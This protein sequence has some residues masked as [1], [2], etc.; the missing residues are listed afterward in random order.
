VLERQAHLVGQVHRPFPVA[1]LPSHV[2]LPILRL[3]FV[4][5]LFQDVGHHFLELVVTRGDGK[6][7]LPETVLL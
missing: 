7:P 5:D 6:L 4:L 3:R 2:Q 1:H